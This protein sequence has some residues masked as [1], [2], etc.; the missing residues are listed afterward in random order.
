[1]NVARSTYGRLEANRPR[2][3][4]LLV[5]PTL[6]VVFVLGL[7]FIGPKIVSATGGDPYAGARIVPV[8]NISTINIDWNADGVLDYVIQVE[9]V[10]TISENDDGTYSIWIGKA[11]AIEARPLGQ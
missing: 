11:V 4:T 2:L 9:S 8:D 6:I 7:V 5:W 10:G 3:F 1:M